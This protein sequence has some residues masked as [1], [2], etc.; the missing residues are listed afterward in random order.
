MISRRSSAGTPRMFHTTPLMFVLGHL[1]G[2]RVGVL[3]RVGDA[4]QATG[5]VTHRAFTIF[6]GGPS[7]PESEPHPGGTGCVD[8]DPH[9]PPEAKALVERNEMRSAGCGYRRLKAGTMSTSVARPETYLPET[10]GG[11]IAQVYDFLEAH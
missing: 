4:G 11:Q 6:A 1:A 8:H 10:S 5:R 9:Q 2:L 3:L 7:Y